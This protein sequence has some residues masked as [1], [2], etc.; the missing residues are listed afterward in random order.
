MQQFLVADET[1]LG[2]GSA[3]QLVMQSAAEAQ[4]P[5]QQNSSRVRNMYVTNV[6]QFLQ[7]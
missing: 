4:K 1:T 5:S 6:K 3:V 2:T 7:A